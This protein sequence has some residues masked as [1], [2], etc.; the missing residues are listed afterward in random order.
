MV[1]S[2]RL[3]IIVGKNCSGFGRACDMLCFS[4]GEN[5]ATNRQGIPLSQFAIHCQCPCRIVASQSSHILLCYSD[6]FTSAADAVADKWD[7]LGNNLFDQKV[8]QVNKKMKDSF[9]ESVKLSKNHDLYLKFSNGFV[10]ETFICSSGP[11]EQWRLLQRY[12]AHMVVCGE[13]IRIDTPDQ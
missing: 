10:F 13:G 4:I 12:G 5:I 3:Q 7:E 11:E 2:E 1:N 9:V 8:D 6:I